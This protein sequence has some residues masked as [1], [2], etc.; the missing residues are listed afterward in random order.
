MVGVKVCD[1]AAFRA[2]E[3]AERIPAVAHRALHAP[4]QT[5]DDDLIGLWHL[6]LPGVPLEIVHGADVAVAL[7]NAARR[8]AAVP[9]VSEVV[10]VLARR[11]SPSASGST[12]RRLVTALRE[13]DRVTPVVLPS[14]RR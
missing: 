7:T 10:V 6:W 3:Y 8:Q 11:T 13:V 1:R 5:N 2:F 14:P 12:L 4:A 9:D